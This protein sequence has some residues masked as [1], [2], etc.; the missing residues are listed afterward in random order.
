MFDSRDSLYAQPMIPYI[1]GA[2]GGVF[3]SAIGAAL[4]DGGFALIFKLTGGFIGLAMFLLGFIELIDQRDVNGHR[5]EQMRLHNELLRKDTAVT[6]PES[7]SVPVEIHVTHQT[8]GGAQ[9][10][11]NQYEPE[12]IPSA[13]FI[14]WLFVRKNGSGRIPSERATFDE[15]TAAANPWIETMEGQGLIEKIG[16][17]DNAPRRVCNGVT[18]E[19][20][21]AR[22]GYPTPLPPEVRVGDARD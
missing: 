21:L 6:Y 10:R 7:K 3:I 8:P 16:E 9:T 5:I 15:W 19:D 2:A 1:V 12:Q 11:I 20:A 17:Y 4:G 22:F 14:E 18:V 13:D